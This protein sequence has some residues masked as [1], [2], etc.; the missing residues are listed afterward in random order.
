VV[1]EALLGGNQVAARW[2]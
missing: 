1:V 2:F